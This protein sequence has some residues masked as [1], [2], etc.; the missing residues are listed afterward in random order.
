MINSHAGSKDVYRAI[1]EANGAATILADADHLILMANEAFVRLIGYGR[2]EIEN[3]RRWTDFISQNELSPVQNYCILRQ[4]KP[5]AAPETYVAKLLD[6]AGSSQSVLV[7]VAQTQAENGGIV[8]ITPLF[9]GN[10]TKV[11][12][13]HHRKM[14][15]NVQDIVLIA[16]ADERILAANKAATL[17]YGY[18]ESEIMT[19]TLR[20]LHYLDT[21]RDG[22]F[23]PWNLDAAGHAARN[24]AGR[25]KDGGKFQME[26]KISR[27]SQAEKKLI[28]VSGRDITEKIF[29]EKQIVDARKKIQTL[30]DAIPDLLFY[31]SREGVINNCIMQ[32]DSFHAKLHPLI[33]KNVSELFPTETAQLI[34]CSI[35][36]VLTTKET[37][38]FEYEYPGKKET[39]YF[40]ARMVACNDAEVLAI[41]RD[42]TRR[43]RIER[44]L[45]YLSFHD[46]LTG[47]YN[48]KYFE[49]EMSRMN[50]SRQRGAGVVICDVDGLKLIN[51]SF[52]HT[53]GDGVLRKVAGMIR[54]SFRASDMVAR[55]G[56]DEFAVLLPTASEVLC[57]DACSRIK[58]MIAAYNHVSSV[59]PIG[60]S[61]GYAM[62][63]TAPVNLDEL[64]SEAEKRVNREKLHNLKSSRSAI[65]NALMR[66]LQVKDFLT[67]GHC[68]RLEELVVQLAKESGLE[69]ECLF[70]LR[71]FARLHDIGKVGIPDHILFKPDKLTDAEFAVMKSHAEIGYRTALSI[72]DLEPIAEWIRLH[73]EWWNGAGYPTGA[74]RG[75]IPK[76]C[77]ILAV[78]DAFDAMTHDR[79]YRKALSEKMAIG[80]LRRNAGIQFDPEVV[81]AFLACRSR[82]EPVV[83]P[84][85]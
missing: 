58:N 61:I 81:E 52:G 22:P 13:D 68:D 65:V 10:R 75:M 25:R 83:A 50:A 23:F 42:D 80:E 40:S 2:G 79:P 1:F 73:H 27:I 85:S 5:Q 14:F 31:V 9:A 15:D 46:S 34:L 4:T 18:D 53:V 47:L 17:A 63:D 82:G 78:A 67:E 55:V 44:Q 32:P 19:M 26:A 20:D 6:R 30:L 7:T 43:K 76:A 21:R 36:R 71:L 45:R 41:V 84:G 39:L 37:E 12:F 70:D 33:G 28:M 59:T 35:N 66:S 64:F 49:Q 60:V 48:R 69:E 8:S 72:P 62:S 16:D 77:R 29:H 74:A 56:G 3:R 24:L 11:L 54:S 57:R 38:S 51:D